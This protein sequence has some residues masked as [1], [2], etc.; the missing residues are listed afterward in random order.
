MNATTEDLRYPEAVGERPLPV[1][2]MQSYLSKLMATA[3]HNADVTKR[4]YEIMTLRRSPVGM[5]YPDVLWAMAQHEVGKR[6]GRKTTTSPPQAA[7]H[8][9]KI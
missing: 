9:Q 1:R 7:M 3:H 5:F 2:F 8:V 6:F 4:F